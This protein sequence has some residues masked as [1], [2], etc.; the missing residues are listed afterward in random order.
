MLVTLGLG[1]VG[2]RKL[3]PPNRPGGPSSE[4]SSLPLVQGHPLRQRFSEAIS[5]H[6]QEPVDASWAEGASRDFRGTLS[7]LSSTY[8]FELVSVGCRTATCLAD[9]SWET[10][11]AGDAVGALIGAAYPENCKRA[12]ST[13]QLHPD[14]RKRIHSR[15]IF[16]CAEVRVASAS[17]NT[18]T[19]GGRSQ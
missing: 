15:L 4:A 1:F 8:G 12:I 19:A 7:S 3:L 13:D 10:M 18:L 16:D 17:A 2:G 6:Q 9:L 11:P 5:L 14:S